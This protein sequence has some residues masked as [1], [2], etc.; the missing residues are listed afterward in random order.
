VGQSYITTKPDN[1]L[2][3]DDGVYVKVVSKEV[4]EFPVIIEFSKDISL[5]DCL[6]YLQ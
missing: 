6:Y 2:I 3:E 1:Y 4:V 5:I